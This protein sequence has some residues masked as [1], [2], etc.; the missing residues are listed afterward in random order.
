M[1]ALLQHYNLENSQ[2]LNITLWSH[3]KHRNLKL[4]QDLDETVAQVID[5]AHHLIE[6]FSSVNSVTQDTPAR[7]LLKTLLKGYR[8]LITAWPRHPRLLRHGNVH[9]T[10]E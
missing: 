6:E 8:E 1:F 4:W 10:V 9:I 7:R 3:W 2:R 5:R